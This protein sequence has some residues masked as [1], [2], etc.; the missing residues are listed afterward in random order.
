VFHAAPFSYQLAEWMLWQ[1]QRW[2]A[3]RPSLLGCVPLEWQ[4]IDHLS[5]W[6]RKSW[7]GKCS[8]WTPSPALAREC[9]AEFI[10]AWTEAPLTTSALSLIPRVMQNEWWSVN[11]H[12][13]TI[14]VYS[15]SELPFGLSAPSHMPYVLLYV[16]CHVRSVD[17][18]PRM[19]QFAP[20]SQ[21]KWHVLQ[22]EQVRGL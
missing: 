4:H 20:S 6:D 22:A 3:E 5:Q 9:I 16:P 13:L 14:G 10:L 21:Q 11:K 12:V 18:S 17:S 19:D 2:L 7:F 15:S 8:L 1:E